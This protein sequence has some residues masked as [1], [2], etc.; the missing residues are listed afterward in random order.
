MDACFREF[1]FGQSVQDGL[2]R[3]E[4]GASKPHHELIVLILIGVAA[5]RKEGEKRDFFGRK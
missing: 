1:F 5:M 3:E 2:T 4:S